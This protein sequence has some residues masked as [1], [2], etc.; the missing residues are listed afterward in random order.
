M[1]DHRITYLIRWYSTHVLS[2][3]WVKHIA[4]RSDTGS[5]MLM[6]FLYQHTM[7][8]MG[9]FLLWS[10]TYMLIYLTASYLIL[11]TDPCNPNPCVH[12]RCRAAG[13]SYSCRCRAGYTG[14]TC[15]GNIAIAGVWYTIYTITLKYNMI[16]V[17][18]YLSL[19][20]LSTTNTFYIY[21]GNTLRNVYIVLV[22]REIFDVQPLDRGTDMDPCGR[23]PFC[24]GLCNQVGTSYTWLGYY[25]CTLSTFSYKKMFNVS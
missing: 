23:N 17:T 20:Y 8:Q 5:H 9:I 4:T 25:G 6:Q 11:D 7:Y 14:S 12:G 3:T 1:L 13:T 15:S 2:V 24:S 21:W 19:V 16:F 18:I 10:Y 22:S